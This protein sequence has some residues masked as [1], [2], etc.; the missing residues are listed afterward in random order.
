MSDALAHITEAHRL[1]TGEA[2]KLPVATMQETPLENFCVIAESLER[3]DCAIGP[4][5]ESMFGQM[6][7]T[8]RLAYVEIIA[9]KEALEKG[10]T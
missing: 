7:D 9:A 5:G 8:I 6:A 4:R 2:F 3:V 1:L 10:S